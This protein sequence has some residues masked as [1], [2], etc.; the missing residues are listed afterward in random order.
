MKFKSSYL[1]LDELRDDA[2]R[3]GLDVDKHFKGIYNEAGDIVATFSLSNLGE[4]T[5]VTPTEFAPIV[6]KTI[7]CFVCGF[8]LEFLEYRS[9]TYNGVNYRNVPNGWT[10]CP[11]CGKSAA[12]RSWV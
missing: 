11:K 10:D 8:K 12:I 4:V 1:T 5:N 9:Q 2:A 7:I 3:Q 6:E